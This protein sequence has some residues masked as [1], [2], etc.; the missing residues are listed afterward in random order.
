VH[1]NPWQAVGVA[2]AI[3]ALAGMAV[4]ILVGRSR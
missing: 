4:G 1:A 2:A 3:G